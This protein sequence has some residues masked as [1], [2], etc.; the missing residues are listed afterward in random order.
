[1]G[2]LDIAILAFILMESA[3]VIILYFFPDFKYGNGIAVFDSW[4]DSF[5]DENMN[6]FAKYM[7]NWV[8]GVKLI[9]ILLLLV[10]MICGSE[11]VKVWGVVC[12][13]LSIATYYAGLHPIIKKLDKNGKITPGGYSK[14][15]FGMITGFMLMFALALVIYFV[16][17]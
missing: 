2:V 15:L 6:L 14:A 13:I 11:I 5:S 10:I 9:F 12:M 16:G 4:R 17:M 7:K 3:N 1:M 8:A